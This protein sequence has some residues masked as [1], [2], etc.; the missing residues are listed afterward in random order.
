M[1]KVVTIG[2]VLLRLSPPGYERFLQASTLEMAYGGAEANVAIALANWGINSCFVTQLPNNDIG[3]SA[4]NNLRKYGVDTRYI[5]RK[6]DRI[7][8]YY[9]EKGN[10]TRTS[11]VIY[12]RANSAMVNVNLDDFDF[13]EIFKDANWF[14]VSG[15]TLALGEKCIA[16]VE[17]AINEAKK[18]K[19]GISV[20]LNYRSKLWTLE[21]FENVLPRFLEDIDVCFGWL[22]SI[23]GKQKEYNVANFAKDK[24]DEEMFTNIF[25][26]MREKFRIKYVVSTLRETYSASHN[27]LSAIIYDG[28]ELYKS[29]R[30]DFSVH[31]RVGAGD[32]FAAGLIYGLVNGENHKEALEFGVA[33]AVIKHSIE[34]D[35][36]LVSSDEVLALR[37]GKGIQSVNR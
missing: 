7:G 21:E 16:L 27:A 6:G 1:K 33:A 25:S 36:D 15:I 35:V 29:A 23:E 10:S 9:L 31:D 4:I 14:H 37:N 12:D 13:Q 11:N 19:I 34:G 28:N 32:S 22:S 8:L 2:E 30:Y 5:Q 3:Q 18:R 24:L 20:D 26:K 17:K